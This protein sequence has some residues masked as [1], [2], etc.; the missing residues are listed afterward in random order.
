MKHKCQ[1]FTDT[2]RH[3]GHYRPAIGEMN[4]TVLLPIQSVLWYKTQV[5]L[6]IQV[7]CSMV[8]ISLQTLKDNVAEVCVDIHGSVGGATKRFWEEMRRHYYVTPSSYMGLIRIYSRM[9]KDKKT[10][11]MGN[12]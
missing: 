3:Q 4:K 7:K 9:L 1:I 12:R 8:I 6:P 5:L 10:E 11:V 2:P